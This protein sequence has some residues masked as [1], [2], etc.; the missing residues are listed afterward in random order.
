MR[1][2]LL[3]ILACGLYGAWQWKQGRSEAIAAAFDASAF[4]AVEMPGGVP[5]NTVL[6]LAPANCPSDQAQRTEAL[7]EALGRAGVPVLRDTGFAFDVESPT[8]EQIAGINRAVSV[9]KRGAPAVF[10]NGLAMSNPTAEQAIAA[11]R[12]SGGRR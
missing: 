2:L 3:V 4:V 7:V 11:Y 5:R 8:A 6:V 1:L 10:V 12:G 9:F